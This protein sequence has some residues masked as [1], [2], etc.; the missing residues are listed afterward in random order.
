MAT[1]DLLNL[2]GLALRLEAEAP[3]AV[4]DDHAAWRQPLIATAARLRI[5]AFACLGLLAVTLAA[6]LGLAARAA[7][8]AS[9]R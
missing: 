5:F 3:G 9:G 6:V 2:E 1:D 4:Y 7:L 8:A